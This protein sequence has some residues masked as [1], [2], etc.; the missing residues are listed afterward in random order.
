[1]SEPGKRRSGR[2]YRLPTAEELQRADAD[3]EV[4][5]LGRVAHHYRKSESDCPYSADDPLRGRWIAGFQ[6]ASKRQNRLDMSP[7]RASGFRAFQDGLHRDE[8]P[9][10]FLTPERSEWVEGWEH[11]ERVKEKYDDE[12]YR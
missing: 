5:R 8:C 1:M 12:H 6:A 4:E 9:L 3:R 7:A 10:G 2:S 11:A